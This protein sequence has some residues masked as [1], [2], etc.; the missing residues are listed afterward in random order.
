MASAR[1]TDILPRD[2]LAIPDTQLM[3]SLSVEQKARNAFRASGVIAGPG[4]QHVAANR[5]NVD[6]AVAA[7]LARGRGADFVALYA[8]APADGHGGFLGFLHALRA[9]SAWSAAM[10]WH[11]FAEFVYRLVRAR[12]EWARRP[13]APLDAAQ[14]SATA[15][16]VGALL[17]ALPDFWA[18]CQTYVGSPFMMALHARA[19]LAEIERAATARATRRGVSDGAGDGMASAGPAGSFDDCLDREISR[20]FEAMKMD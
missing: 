2:G 3:S 8:G 9:A 1:L 19:N 6:A 12:T 11:V 16:Q 13:R 7:L 5:R 4:R 14:H 18:Q 15:R 10:P 20:G 17:G